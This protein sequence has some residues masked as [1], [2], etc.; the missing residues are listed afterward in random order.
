LFVYG[1]LRAGED[2]AVA[3]LL[4]RHA[5]HLGE[6]TIHARLYAVTWYCAAVACENED[7]RVHGDVFALDPAAAGEVL[8]ALDAYEGSDFARVPVAV[9]LDDE[10]SLSAESYLFAASV[11]E[12]RRVGHGDWRRERREGGFALPDAS[13]E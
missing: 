5:R 11:A 8:A 10:T 1:S 4:H 2:N 13:P 12:L 6:G 9:A 7:A 3:R